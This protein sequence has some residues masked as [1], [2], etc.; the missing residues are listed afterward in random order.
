M[1]I[2][3]Y[4]SGSLTSINEALWVTSSFFT[5]GMLDSKVYKVG[6]KLCTLLVL[7]QYIVIGWCTSGIGTVQL[8]MDIY[9][10]ES[11]AVRVCMLMIFIT[12]LVVIPMVQ[13]PLWHNAHPSFW[14][15]LREKGKGKGK[16]N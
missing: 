4:A 10:G 14:K 15:A 9:R 11:V 5:Q 7:S 16:G 13:I 8:M 1:F 6:Q 3:F 12:S 2:L